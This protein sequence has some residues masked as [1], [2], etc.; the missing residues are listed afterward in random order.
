MWIAG[1]GRGKKKKISVCFSI[2]EEPALCT[3]II[4]FKLYL[5]KVFQLV[6]VAIEG[7][8]MICREPV[9]FIGFSKEELQQSHTEVSPNT[10][11]LAGKTVLPLGQQLPAGELPTHLQLTQ[12][13][14]GQRDVS[15]Q[16]HQQPPEPRISTAVFHFPRAAP[17]A[18]GLFPFANKPMALPAQ[19]H[20]HS[21]HLCAG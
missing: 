16:I 21:P 8:E 7:D 12:K 9:D 19:C 4:G 15:W 3:L 1:K 5:K 18:Q 6:A 13:P 10:I 17:C 20:C 11:R 2:N 14:W